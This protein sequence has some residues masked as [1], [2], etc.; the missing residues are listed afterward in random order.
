[1]IASLIRTFTVILLCIFPFGLIFRLKLFANVQI[2]PQDVLVLSIFSLIVLDYIR[3]RKFDTFLKFQF[4]F[5]II[6]IVS[7]V[8][9]ELIF[10]DINLTSA[11]LYAIRYVS[12]IC[13]I[14]VGSYFSKL[15]IIKYLV[16][17]SGVAFI[18]F[19]FFQYY[20]YNSLSWL[21]YLGWDNHLYR[22]FSTFFDPN[23]AGV[24]YVFFLFI[25]FYFQVGK[26][27]SESYI[28]LLLMFFDF[29]AIIMTYSR[30]ALIALV[31]GVFAFCILKRKLKVFFAILF[32]LI[33]SLLLLSDVMVEGLNPFRTASSTDRIVSLN[34]VSKIILNNP[35][36]GVGFNGFADAQKRFGFRNP[37]GVSLSN[38]DYGTDN[39]ILFAFATTGIIGVILYIYSYFLLLKLL[40]KDNNAISIYLFCGLIALIFGGIF[41]NVLFYTPIL[42]FVFITISLRKNF[43]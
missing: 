5:L 10:K 18:I 26:R 4:L 15:N 17:A 30:T 43:N 38:A 23:F 20:F 24:F 6:G 36:I 3:T 9:N 21:W 13:L 14:R 1:M 35:V 28:Y 16:L 37:I 39:S 11:I 34:N 19:G 27:L 40:I 22:L 41:L 31:A 12:Y 25:I 32:F 7:L 8:L 29:L 2:V 42:S 33:V